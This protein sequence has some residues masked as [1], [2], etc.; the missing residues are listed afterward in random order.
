MHSKSK[1]FLMIAVMA[2]LCRLVGGTLVH[3]FVF[4]AEG[5]R[6]TQSSEPSQPAT[7]NAWFAELKI[8]KRHRRIEDSLVHFV[9]LPSSFYA[10][11]NVAMVAVLSPP[12]K[13]LAPTPDLDT[14]ARPPC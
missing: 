12:S 8:T 2:V 13:D 14:S 1:Y 11:P 3:T 10:F 7:D 5:T 4:G 6:I 9:A